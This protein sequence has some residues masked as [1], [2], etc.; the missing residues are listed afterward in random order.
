MGVNDLVSGSEMIC[1]ASYLLRV[2]MDGPKE[3]KWSR[4]AQRRQFGDKGA[5]G[6]ERR[7]GKR[8]NIREIT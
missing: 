8:E 3:V 7:R 2:V 6:K 4:R 1:L 5:L